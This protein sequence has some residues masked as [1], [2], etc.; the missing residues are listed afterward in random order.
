M[1]RIG[2]MARLRDCI[3]RHDWAKITLSSLVGLGG[4]L[5]M[6]SKNKPAEEA[7]VQ[8][9][10]RLRHD[11]ELFPSLPDEAL[12]GRRVVSAVLGRSS[13]TIYRDV[14]QGRLAR[15]V[16]IG[17]SSRWHVGSVRAALRALQ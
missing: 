1:T 7:S 5:V 16:H 9:A 13:A 6:N 3:Q 8:I 17:G 12:I 15:P 2:Q 14:A 4:K 11:L 10:T